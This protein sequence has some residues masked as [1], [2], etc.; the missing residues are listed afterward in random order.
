M[1]RLLGVLVVCF[2]AGRG[3][4]QPYGEVQSAIA[5]VLVL[6]VAVHLMGAFV[7]WAVRRLLAKRTF[8]Y[9]RAIVSWPLIIVMFFIV[10]GAGNAARNLEEQDAY[11]E[12]AVACP[13]ADVSQCRTPPGDAAREEQREQ[14]RRALV[15]FMAALDSPN[16]QRRPAFDVAPL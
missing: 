5:Y 3:S 1:V 13:Q 6:G 11:V 16:E 9:G 4:S 7:L 10:S 15:T 8:S 14:E 12:Q 2:S